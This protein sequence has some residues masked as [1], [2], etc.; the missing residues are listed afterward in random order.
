MNSATTAK[1]LVQGDIRLNFAMKC[2]KPG[3][4][5]DEEQFTIGAE[6]LVHETAI[7]AN[8]N[9]PNIIKLYGRALGQ[10]TDAFMLN[11]GYFII[12]EKLDETL[13]DRMDAWKQTKRTIRE[14][15][16]KQIKV[17]RSIANAMAYLHSRC[18]V[19]RDLKPANVGFDHMGCLKLFDFGFAVALPRKDK[20]NPSGFLYD[21]C[22]TP[23]YMAPEIGKSLG[24][25][26]KADV[27]SF[28][29]LMWEMCALALPFSSITSADEFNRVVFE[30]GAR[31]ELG[32]Y[33]PAGVKTLICSCWSASPS[34]RPTMFDVKSSLSLSVAS[35]YTPGV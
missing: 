8:M 19:F 17:A 12:L 30:E 25:E 23:R 29:I 9:H 2:L 5:A 33:W 21:R 4:R 26:A 22:G 16:S 11:D 13:H 24:Y 15:K 31:P 32:E 20:L 10:L 3:V 14:S 1:P 34:E 7:L 6:D 18:V 35:G 27:Y 28:G